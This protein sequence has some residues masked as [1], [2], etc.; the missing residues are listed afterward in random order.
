MDLH[1]IERAS[2]ASPSSKLAM[3]NRQ[4]ERV[5]LFVQA[6]RYG[7]VTRLDEY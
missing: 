7:T 3:L 1:S 6:G 4:F 5:R 2:D